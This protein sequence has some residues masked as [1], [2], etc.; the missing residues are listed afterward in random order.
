[1]TEVEKKDE[2][3]FSFNDNGKEHKVEELS[4]ENRLLYNKT[5]LCNQ[6]IARLQQDIARLQFEIEIKQL[7]AAKYSGELKDAVEGDEPKVEVA[8]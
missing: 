4:D 7:A 3:T 8:K 2:L 1:M 5:V 6:E